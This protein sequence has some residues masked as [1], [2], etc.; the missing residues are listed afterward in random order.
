MKFVVLGATS[1]LGRRV[2]ARLCDLGHAVVAT[3]RSAERLQLVDPRTETAMASMA[4]ADTLRPLLASADRIIN[5]AHAS[6]IEQLIALVPGTCQRLIVI[7][8]TRRD[9]EVPDPG[10]DQV[11]H[12]EAIFLGADLPGAILHPTMIYGGGGG[13]TNVARILSLVRRWPRWLPM[14]WPVPDGGKALVQPVYID[15]VA[16]ALVAA[17]TTDAALARSIVV[18][19]PQPIPLADMLRS[20]ADAYGRRLGILPVPSNV[21]ISVMRLLAAVSITGPFSIAELQRSREDKS[22]DIDALRTE[23]GVEP[24]SF[25]EGIRLLAAEQLKQTK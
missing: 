17:A 12:G 1:G 14:L 13:E 25:S 9:S 20:C 2:V 18:A 5:I 6:T 21:L 23:L 16:S 11:R 10:A 3:G 19:G 15:D 4:D 24:R 8:S 22:Y 7:G